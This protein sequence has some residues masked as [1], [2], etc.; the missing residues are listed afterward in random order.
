MLEGQ[1]NRRSSGYTGSST[2]DSE[3]VLLHGEP[4][5]T[6]GGSS[7]GSSG[8]TA[9]GSTDTAA[10]DDGSAD[11][12]PQTP[13]KTVDPG[14][15]FAAT[16]IARGRQWVDVGMPYCGGPNHGGDVLCGGTCVRSGAS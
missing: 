12:D 13:S 14:D 6:M 10:D 8:S 1:S 16:T 11:Y 15:T 3:S 2:Q 7:S 9:S 5:S 4:G